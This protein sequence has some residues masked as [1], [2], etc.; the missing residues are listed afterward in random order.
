VSANTSKVF[1]VLSQ[2][3]RFSEIL[4]GLIMTLSITGTMSI[5]SGGREEVRIM[6]LSVLGCN[7]AWGIID[8]IL[9][10]LGIISDRSRGYALY[11]LVRQTRDREKART[12][13]EEVLP[14]A[15]AGVLHPE[16]FENI[17]QRLAA[18][19][20][21]PRRRVITRQD[22]MGAIGVFLLVSL[23]CVPLMIPFLFMSDPLPAL[24]VSNAIA[25]A[26]LFLGGYSFA[27]YA[28]GAK[29]PT[30]LVMVVLGVVMVGITI[31]LG[32]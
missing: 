4:F 27:K 26:M 9:Y 15:I 22:L 1:G 25:I 8:A 24:R 10:L 12:A 11:T 13:I 18:L 7:I 21:L 23:S 14:P 30:G 32:G 17:H 16:D 3:E 20:D 31:A 6:W 29:I 28:G 2:V 5:V 19:S